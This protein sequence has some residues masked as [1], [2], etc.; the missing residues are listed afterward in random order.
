MNEVRY[1]MSQKQLNRYTVISQLI[2]GNLTTQE[3]AE[4]LGLSE[5]QVKRLKKGVIE[6]F[7]CKNNRTKKNRKLQEC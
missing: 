3:A 4:R 6:W 5:R 7:S 2:E 1:L